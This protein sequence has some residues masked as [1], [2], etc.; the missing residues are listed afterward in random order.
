MKHFLKLSILA[1]LLVA[2]GFQRGEAKPPRG[3]HGGGRTVY[4][5][6]WGSFSTLEA[7]KESMA[8]VP[9]G[10]EAPIYEGRANGR[11]VY[12]HCVGCYYSKRKA[13]EAIN[14]FNSTYGHRDIWIWPS[15]GLAKCVYCPIGLSGY[16][17]TPLRPN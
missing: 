10:M 3:S 6:V 9:D 17:L 2:V 14:V 1:V 4:Y 13:Q 16:R 8:M 11:T 15:K 5:V 7:A 12:R